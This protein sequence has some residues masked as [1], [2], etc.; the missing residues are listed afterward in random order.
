MGEAVIVEALRSPIAR[1]KK[2]KGA[3]S[4]FHSAHLLSK[5]QHGVVD[6]AGID[7][8]EIE[9][10][11]GGGVTQVGEHS[12]NVIRHSWLSVA[13]TTRLPAPPS[14]PSAARASKPT[15]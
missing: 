1:G 2:I 10:I 6:K 15:M 4:G 11:I 3:L 7:A 8:G 14:T 13:R 9:Q 12:S 5:V